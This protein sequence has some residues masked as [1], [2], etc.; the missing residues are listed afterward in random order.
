MKKQ[1]LMLL[2]GDQDFGG[3]AQADLPRPGGDGTADL[4]LVTTTD[5]VLAI[6]PHDSA[7]AATATGYAQLARHDVPSKPGVLRAPLFGRLRHRNASGDFI[8]AQ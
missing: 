2:I 4:T 1:R 5:S 8:T 6:A 7:D 3:A